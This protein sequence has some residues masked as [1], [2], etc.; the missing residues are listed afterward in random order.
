MSGTMDQAI[1]YKHACKVGSRFPGTSSR[2][3]SLPSKLCALHHQRPKA[4]KKHVPKL[5]GNKLFLE[6][7]VFN[8]RFPINFYP[9]LSFENMLFPIPVS[10]KT[11]PT[12]LK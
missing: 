10:R 8:R 12:S 11:L 3:V 2:V 1:T 4:S 9:F 6:R 5:T 7:W